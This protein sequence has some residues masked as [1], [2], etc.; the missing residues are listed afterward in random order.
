MCLLQ[1][2]LVFFGLEV[3][4]STSAIELVLLAFE[5]SLKCVDVV[6]EL[7]DSLTVR[8]AVS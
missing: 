3:V 1:N 8:I 5:F 7:A 2:S 6:V 4:F